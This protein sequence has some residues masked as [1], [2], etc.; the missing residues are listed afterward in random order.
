M[1][2]MPILTNL[3]VALCLPFP[4]KEC[5]SLQIEDFP[6]QKELRFLDIF[7]HFLNDYELLSSSKHKTRLKEL[8]WLKKTV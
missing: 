6:L 3:L 7:S 5:I 2:F 8:T 4:S 1:L